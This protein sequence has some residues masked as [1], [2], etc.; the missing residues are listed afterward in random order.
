[1]VNAY[2]VN[3]AV[4]MVIVVNH[5]N[6]AVRRKVVSLNLVNVG[7]IHIY[8]I[9]KMKFMTKKISYIYKYIDNYFYIYKYI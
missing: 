6:I 3:V 5:P 7:K 9:V 4:N 1:M 2:L 8:R